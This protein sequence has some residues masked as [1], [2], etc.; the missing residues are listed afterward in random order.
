MSTGGMGPPNFLFFGMIPPFLNT[1][2]ASDIISRYSIFKWWGNY[3]T[4][5][6]GPF[7]SSLSII[8]YSQPVEM[9]I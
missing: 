1:D 9:I 5:H 7:A 4:G 3:D 2:S 8:G 6:L